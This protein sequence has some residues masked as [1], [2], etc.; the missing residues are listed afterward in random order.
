MA[1]SAYGQF[2]A[3]SLASISN[4]P[5][6]TLLFHNSAFLDAW[7]ASPQTLALQH[8][9]ESDFV[10]KSVD[11]Q[12][13]RSPFRRHGKV[14]TVN[15]WGEQVWK[16]HY[17][18]KKTG[19]QI[20]GEAV[21][22]DY[23]V[24][25]PIQHLILC[26][27]PQFILPTLLA[28]RHRLSRKS[29]VLIICSGLGTIEEVLE[30]DIFPDEQDRP[31]FLYGV[32]NH[33]V[34]RPNIS[35]SNR[36]PRHFQIHHTRH[37]SLYISQDPLY[38]TGKK[39]V[40]QLI[41]EPNQSIQQSA[42]LID[43][44]LQSPRLSGTLMAPLDLHM[45]QLE[46]LALQS[47]LLPLTALMDTHSSG[48]LSNYPLTRTIRL[49]LAETSLVIR[50]LPE[51]RGHPNI[52]TRFAPDRLERLMVKIARDSAPRS[53]SMLKDVRWGVETE[54]DYMNGYIVKRGEELGVRCFLNYMIMQMIIGKGNIVNAEVKANAPFTPE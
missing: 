44:L 43:N 39:M 18:A 53:S 25:D 13:A 29:S 14:V 32:M 46:T 19:E 49:L 38:G 2:I 31:K 12:M 27:K 10:E 41:A 7:R 40:D 3:H 22:P 34:E 1:D 33:Y 20:D 35:I 28:V 54:V 4:P 8:D 6:I 45:Q 52:E 37:G 23:H 42:Y 30:Q 47:V 21:P 15:E 9:N 24:K 5:P 51:L 17:D 36:H 16:P 11:V 50:S 48:L 26:T